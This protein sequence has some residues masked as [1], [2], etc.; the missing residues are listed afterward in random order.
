MDFPTRAP[1]EHTIKEIDGYKEYVVT[2]HN[3]DDLQSFY[4]D[5]E[6]PGGDLY[7]PNRA[8]GLYKRRPLSRNTHYLL[9]D[10]ERDTVAQDSRV[11]DV[12]LADLIRAV[13][14]PFRTVTGNFNK[15]ENT[16]ASNHRNWA[17]LR[18][19]ETSQ[20]NNWGTNGTADQ[21]DTV[22]LT[23]SGK[24]V[25]VIIVDGHCDPSH[26]ELAVNADGTGGSRVQSF[27]W[28]SLNST[29][30]SIDDDNRTLPSGSYTYGPYVDSGNADPDVGAERTS[31]NNHG[32]HVAGTVAGNTYGWAKDATIYNIEFG[33]STDPNDMDSLLLYDYIRAFHQTKNIN[34]ETGVKN[35][36]ICNGSY[37]A[38]IGWGFGGSTFGPITRAVYRG[39]DTGESSTP[40]TGSQ[41]RANGI[42]DYGYGNNPGDAYTGGSSYVPI[43]FTSTAAD[44]EDMVADG[45]H[46]V[47]ASGNDYF[48]VVRSTDD[49][50]YNNIFYAE[51]QGINYFWYTH[52]GTAPGISDS[53]INVGAVGIQTDDRKTVFSNCGTGVD[54][55]A[56][57]EGI[58]S[59]THTGSGQSNQADSR[60]GS[61]YN[62]NYQG[63]SMASPQVCGILA[64]ALETY[65]RMTP[66]EAKQYLIDY[67]N[68]NQMLD[69]TFNNA[70]S[71]SS[72]QGSPNRM[73]RYYYERPVNGNVY[74]KKNM[75]KRPSSGAV[76]PRPRIRTGGY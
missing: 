37:G 15:D 67:A 52:R 16:I 27:N 73:V 28:Y 2:L 12:Q 76:W 70:N 63:T 32:S 47:A 43:L 40:L 9:T 25:D 11:A 49:N 4:N 20:R 39:V 66:A 42:V 65:P 60:N 21:T 44:I 5:M 18:C 45:I 74:P 7:I 35:P 69:G 51:Y 38:S 36:T 41:L 26:P 71:L 17:H 30:S 48:K 13:V 31:N 14:Q 34:S 23:S 46:F 10:E 29:V 59:S 8:V 24:N 64:C 61:Y 55:Y 33:S 22:T 72:L 58:T 50:D 1:Q 57:G 62:S 6:T 56:P 54:I 19:T 53:V 75:K 3:K 68:D